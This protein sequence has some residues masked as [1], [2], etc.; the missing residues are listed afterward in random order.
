M[1]GHPIQFFDDLGRQ[2]RWLV[3]C[4]DSDR[5]TLYL[6]SLSHKHVLADFA[7]GRDDDKIIIYP[8]WRL[9]AIV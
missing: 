5:E 6:Q 9:V 4:G 3:L 7:A 8:F 1:P 2:R